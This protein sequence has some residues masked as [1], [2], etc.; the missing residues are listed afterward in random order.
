[1]KLA[2]LG[3]NMTQVSFPDGTRVLYSYNTAVAVFLSSE[4]HCLATS[5]KWGPTT[6]K[7]IN[8]WLNG[9]AAARIPQE[10][11]E[12]LVGTIVRV[13]RA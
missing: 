6:S 5:K 4:P 8:K 12:L 1:M 2:I 7:H 10:E 9:A 13:E 11:L 3:P